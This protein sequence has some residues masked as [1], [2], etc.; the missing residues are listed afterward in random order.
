[1]CDKP[2]D[3]QTKKIFL[4]KCEKATNKVV[5]ISLGHATLQVTLPASCS[6]TDEMLKKKKET[7]KKLSVMD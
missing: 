4:K 2:T 5:A 6:D 3:R 7:Q 1:M